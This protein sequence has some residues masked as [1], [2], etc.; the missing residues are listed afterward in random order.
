[1]ADIN[2]PLNTILTVVSQ[3]AQQYAQAAQVASQV[4]RG[5]ALAAAAQSAT[6]GPVGPSGA[7]TL[8]LRQS[9]A[10]TQPRTSTKPTGTN[11]TTTTS[12]NTSG[13]TQQQQNVATLTFDVFFTANNSGFAQRLTRKLVS[14]QSTKQTLT[15]F[16]TEEFGIGLGH[17]SLAADCIFTTNPANQ[18][19][20]FKD[21]LYLA[22]RQSPFSTTPPFLLYIHISKTG[23]S[24]QITQN[25]ITIEENA[26]ALNRGFITIEA[27][28]L[29][30]FTGSYS[31]Q[32]QQSLSQQQQLSGGFT[33]NQLVALLPKAFG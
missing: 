8:E 20:A 13:S 7:I 32:T 1:M 24:Y 29:A 33:Q 30:D 17:I 22:K 25:E 19:Q 4:A 10:A 11:T 2:F 26:D 31:A 28:I 23:E 15:G 5:T 18:T 9:A 14:R 21:M 6:G 3:R 27:D 16:Y 12:G